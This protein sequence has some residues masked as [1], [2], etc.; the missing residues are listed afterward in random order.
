M[1]PEM[2]CAC[3]AWLVWLLSALHLRLGEVAVISR[4]S[5]A[6]S[7]WTFLGKNIGTV[8][9]ARLLGHATNYVYNALQLDMRMSLSDSKVS[10]P[11][12]MARHIDAFMLTT[13]M[14]MAETLPDK[15][16]RLV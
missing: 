1:L 13:Y 4:D 14:S 3:H 2:R 16:R 12:R 9:L 8:C 10:R 5:T 11:M 15:H 6:R 7:S